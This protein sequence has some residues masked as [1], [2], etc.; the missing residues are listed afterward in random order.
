MSPRN[1]TLKTIVGVWGENCSAS[2]VENFARHKARRYIFFEG[3]TVLLGDN[4]TGKSTVFEAIELAIGADRLARTQAIDEHDF[5]GG[6]YRAVENQPPEDHRGRGGDRRSLDEQHCTKFR[7]N[8]EFWRT[9]DRSLWAR[10]R[11]AVR[12]RPARSRPFACGLK[13]P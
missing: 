12:R 6:D 10:V 2:H 11:P 8:L 1:E 13:E 3:T 5:Y 9:A 7:N 4:N